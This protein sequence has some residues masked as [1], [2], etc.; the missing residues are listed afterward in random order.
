M[1]LTGTESR[2]GAVT[3]GLHWLTVVLVLAAFVTSEGGS[4]GGLVRRMH[5]SLGL[6]VFAVVLVRLLWRLAD[7]APLAPPMPRWMAVASTLTHGALYVL[8][9]AIPL[10]SIFGTWYE[11]KPIVLI[12]F[13]IAPQVGT[14]RTV[15]KTLL[16][17]H[18]FLGTAIMWIAGLHAVA[19]L[20]H[21]FVLRDNVLKAMLP[22]RK[23]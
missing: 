8:L 12:G 2:Y 14:S 3:Q 10:T 1:T 4:G 17:V 20:F 22:E 7:R 5:E 13:D 15:G 21:H 9:V 11:G 18:E 23:G 19:A 16:E 6:A